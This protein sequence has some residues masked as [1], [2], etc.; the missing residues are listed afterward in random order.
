M[1]QNMGSY[2]KI[3]TEM[4]IITIDGNC[5]SDAEVKNMDDGTPRITFTVAVKDPRNRDQTNW[6]RCDYFGKRGL[7]VQQYIR[8]GTYIYAV[9]SLS[10]GEY[11][12][13]PTFNVTVNELSFINSNREAAPRQ[14][15]PQRKPTAHDLAKQNGYQPQEL[16]DDLPF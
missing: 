8:K 12:G 1:G 11:E 10:I 13:K 5:G 9:G 15:A 14:E 3:G 6:Y 4:Q 7:A 2:G 16:D